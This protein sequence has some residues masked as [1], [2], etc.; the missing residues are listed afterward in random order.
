MSA[1]LLHRGPD[2]Q[3]TL[4]LPEQGIALGHTRLAI[5]DL[6][7]HG[8]QPMLS[9]N[10]RY[11]LTYNGE[12]YNH[13]EVRLELENEGSVFRGHSD[14]E[15]LV[16]GIARWGVATTVAKCIGM[17]AFAVWDREERKLTLARDRAGIKP[18]YYGSIDGDFIFGSELK[19]IVSYHGR[20]PELNKNIIPRYLSLGYIPA[21]ETIYKTISKLLPGTILTLQNGKT[22]TSRYWCPEEIWRQGIE[23]PFSGTEEEALS[24]LERIVGDAVES[25][26]IADVPLG[27]FLSG[28][29]DSSLVTALMQKKLT[30]PVRTFTIGF[31]D[32]AYNEANH[33][34]AVAAHLGT[35][36]TELYCT[37]SDLLDVIPTIPQHWDEP[38]ADSSQIPTLLLS[39]LTRPHVTVA[40][41]GDGGDE[42]F[43]GYQRYFWAAHWSRL[44]KVPLSMRNQLGKV[45]NLIPRKAYS[46]LGS[47]GGKIH[48]RLDLLGAKNYSDF[49]KRLVSMHPTPEEF[50]LNG[51]S[52]ILPDLDNTYDS[53]TA[54]SLWDFQHYLPDDI[55]T[56]VDRASMAYGLEARV[57]LLDHKVVEFAATLPS[58]MNITPNGG[59]SLLKKLLY[60]H[61]PQ[62]LIDRPKKGFSVPIEQWLGNDLKEWC[63]DMLSVEMIQKHGILKPD[64]VQDLWHRY[65][66]GENEWYALL[67][68]ILML[69]N[70]LE[71]SEQ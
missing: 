10:K 13:Q 15:V 36:H 1:T 12:I 62:E 68:T 66:S 50:V 69:Q 14:T 7:E 26:M 48:S 40:L 44:A 58:S 8:S 25:R 38:F 60:R 32:Q 47:R 29:I 39:K 45:S 16:E 17:F 41:S 57:P 53:F 23:T 51:E 20:R 71:T 18:L 63:S 42:L 2:S 46:L 24:E 21:P 4:V 54:A 37:P 28:G 61:I 3:D 9:N 67:W 33:A 49:Y 22:E 56:K 27:A 70:W 34:R 52:S 19:A 31:K 5:I 35:A 11:A 55:L 64:M 65:L 59:K 30:S 43:L 6:S